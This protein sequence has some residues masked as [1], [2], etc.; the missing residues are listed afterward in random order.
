MKFVERW[1]GRNLKQIVLFAR[2]KLFFFLLV[3]KNHFKLL[4]KVGGNMAK[5]YNNNDAPGCLFLILK[6]IILVFLPLVFLYLNGKLEVMQEKTFSI[7][8]GFVIVLNSYLL[9]GRKYYYYMSRTELYGGRPSRKLNFSWLVNLF[10][11]YK[12]GKALIFFI[13]LIFSFSNLFMLTISICDIYLGKG[14]VLAVLKWTDAGTRTMFRIILGLG[15]ISFLSQ[16]ILDRF[17]DRASKWHKYFVDTRRPSDVIGENAFTLT[18]MAAAF[19]VAAFSSNKNFYEDNVVEFVDFATKASMK[20]VFRRRKRKSIA[21]KQYKYSMEKAE[22]YADEFYEEGVD[23]N[24]FKRF[25]RKSLAAYM[26]AE[27]KHVDILEE[28]LVHKT[29]GVARHIVIDPIVDSWF[30]SFAEDGNFNYSN[31]NS[32][33]KEIESFLISP[34]LGAQL[35]GLE[36]DVQQDYMKSLRAGGKYTVWEV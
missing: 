1:G 6:M 8:I 5:N 13:P 28:E 34:Q 32:T 35:S 21:S 4:N 19:L 25:I 23:L 30:A 2:I 14:I 15:V 16:I 20:K 36:N 27:I 22:Q 12:F 33:I 18:N 7:F 10:K 3:M 31:M 9:I 11:S 26:F 17:L 29:I 24:S